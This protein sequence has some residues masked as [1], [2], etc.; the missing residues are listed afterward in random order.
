MI[1]FQILGIGQNIQILIY[2]IKLNIQR[3]MLF[4]AVEPAIHQ[5][6]RVQRQRRQ[7]QNDDHGTA[8]QCDDDDLFLSFVL[9][10]ARLVFLRCVGRFLFLIHAQILLQAFFFLFYHIVPIF[11]MP[12]ARYFVSFLKINLRKFL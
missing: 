8:D 7:V 5:L 3:G 12:H 6:F 10:I 11:A 9:L 2:R 4:V 1:V